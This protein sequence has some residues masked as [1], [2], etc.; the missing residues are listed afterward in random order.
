MTQFF[1]IVYKAGYFNRPDQNWLTIS[2]SYTPCYHLDTTLL[3]N[4]ET[5]VMKDS[6]V[7]LQLKKWDK[8]TCF[9]QKKTDSWGASRERKSQRNL[10]IIIYPS[11]AEKKLQNCLKYMRTI[12]RTLNMLYQIL[13]LKSDQNIPIFSI[14]TGAD[15]HRND[16]N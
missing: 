9:Q 7:V 16:K 11:N 5:L 13:I 10:L 15:N 8:R 1:I 4:F 2:S 3:E 14:K 12:L 6:Q